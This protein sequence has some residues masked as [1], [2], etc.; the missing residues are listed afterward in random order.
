MRVFIG[1]LVCTL[2]T[3]GGARAADALP[4]PHSWGKLGISFEDYRKDAFECTYTSYLTMKQIATKKPR[5]TETPQLIYGANGSVDYANSLY[6]FVERYHLQQFVRTKETNNELQ[7][8]IDGCL[9]RK[10]YKPFLLTQ[11]Q[12]EKLD[13]L[14]KGSEPRHRYLYSL[15][16]DPAV[17]AG[18]AL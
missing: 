7:E 18:Q 2:L 8:E 14:D 10:A 11:A 13:T 6:T 15:A 5:I 16:T 1:L 12:A 17:L 9:R 4:S 3:T